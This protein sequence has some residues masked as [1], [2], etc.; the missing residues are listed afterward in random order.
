MKEYVLGFMFD[1]KGE[2]VALIKKNKPEWQKG[3]FN[4]I[5][6]KV[7]LNEVFWAAMVREFKEETGVEHEDWLWVGEIQEKD[8]KIGVFTCATDKV[9]LTTST[10]DEEVIVFSLETV[11]EFTKEQTI[12]NVPWLVA[13]C[14]DFLFNDS[15]LSH[16]KV[17]YI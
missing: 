4:G 7:E 10:T 9:H 8:W 14:R 17:T 12:S 5:G 13:I 2:W 16:F 1:T 3:R 15:Y 11:K 6:G